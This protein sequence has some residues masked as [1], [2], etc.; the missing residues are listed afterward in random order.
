MKNFFITGTD[1]G[2][3]KTLVSAIITKVLNAT[4]WKPIQSGVAIDIPDRHVVKELTDL[5]SDHFP[6]SAYEL[7]AAL[8]PNQ[9][10]ELENIQVKIEK[11]S[12]PITQRSLIIEG[13]GGVYVPINQQDSMLDLIK[14]FNFPV[15]IVSRGTLGTIN[16]TLLTIEALR[17]QQVLIHGL[18]FNGELNPANQKTIE[19]RAQLRTLFHVPHFGS[20]KKNRLDEWL[21]QQ[22]QNI[23]KELA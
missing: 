5:P 3:G 1:T 12:M 17:K 10:A 8:S 14:Y 15:I 4:Y 7:Q 16:H 6:P 11:C 20:L 22:T 21:N 18:V 19:E 2:V 23:M 9:A 13:A